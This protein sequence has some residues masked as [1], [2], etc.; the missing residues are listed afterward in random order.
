MNRGSAEE[1]QGSETTL[2]NAIMVDTYP[3]ILVQTRT[4]YSIELEL[5]AMGSGW[6]WCIHEGDYACVGEESM[7]EIS[8]SSGQLYCEPKTA[9][10]IV[11]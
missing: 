9:L 7:W 4:K 2:H 8:V 5:W 10:K 1:F 3:Y 11:Y 6:K